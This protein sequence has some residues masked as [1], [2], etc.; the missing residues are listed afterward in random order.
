MATTTSTPGAELRRFQASAV[1]GA[2][3]GRRRSASS[4][5]PATLAPR[6]DK[7]WR[8]GLSVAFIFLNSACGGGGSE[9]L[10]DD[11]ITAGVDLGDTNT[12]AAYHY[13]TTVPVA[14]RQTGV[15]Q[16]R[17]FGVVPDDSRDDTDAIQRALDGLKAGETLV[18][19][20]GRYQISR[21]V[22]VRRPGVTIT[23]PGATIHATNPDSQA[24]LIEAD[25]TT[26]SSLTFTAVT[27]VRRTAAWHA[28]IVI[29]ADQGGGKYKTVRNTV[30]RDNR[31][32]NAGPPGS[33]TANS[34]SAGGIFVTHANGFLI[35]GN[36]VVRTLAD[37]IHITGG[38]KNGRVLNNTV[39]ETGDDMIAVVSYLGN[40]N[41]V[42]N[43]ENSAKRLLATF[44]DRVENALVR[45]VLIAGN[46]VSGQYWGRG[47]SV[48]GGQSI[49]IA[50][51]TIDN[52]PVAA[53]VLLAREANWQT[54]GVENVVV[55][56]NLIRNVQNEAPP[57]DFQGKYASARRTGHGAIELHAA[58][59]EDEAASDLRETLSVGN[60]L[61]RNNVIEQTTV[62]AVRAGVSISGSM[63]ANDTEGHAMERAIVP[64]I[65]R[66]AGF[67]NNRF[68]QVNG[69]AV[70][71]VA[72]DLSARGVYCS[73]NQRDGNNYQTGACKQREAPPAQGAPLTCTP[74]GL[75]IQ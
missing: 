15:H 75:L 54:F 35:A 53:A 59:F 51:N 12:P 71:V 20:P 4:G 6:L 3:R 70:R 41:A 23:G 38:S 18:F 65:V 33:P 43:G 45:N 62:S 1:P 66:N 61:V 50:R 68:N 63:R 19:S 58:L 29:S 25:N 44:N 31:I 46:Q 74:D 32:V 27:D 57:Y 22:R 26:V 56:N 69:D 47:I 11:P 5:Q 52:V 24:L 8:I 37:G 9:P 48:V 21:S 60:V 49:T 42:T 28:R 73:E 7:P 30:I 10:A 34:A 39:R 72:P 40:G 67:V 17:E 13:C 14:A 55:E 64:G 2:D 16:V 36:T